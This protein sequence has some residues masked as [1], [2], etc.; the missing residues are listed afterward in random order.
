M[1]GLT[2]L[3]AVAC[4]TLGPAMAQITFSRSWVPQGKRSS[5]PASPGA[6]LG[7]SEIGDTC[8]EAKMS[9]LSQVATYVTR[10]MEET[11]ILPSDEASLAYHLRQAQISRRR[12]MA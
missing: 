3:L 2:L 5:G 4:L 10:L 8:Q 1:Q 7:Q 9:V 12:R 11:S 6:L